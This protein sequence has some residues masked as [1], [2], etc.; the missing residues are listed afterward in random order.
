MRT[1]IRI[2]AVEA[3]DGHAVRVRFSDGV[4]RDLDLGPMLT[5]GVLLGLRDPDVFTA[6][7]VDPVAGTLVW[8]NDVDLDPDVL[9]G[10]SMPAHGA[11]PTLLAERRP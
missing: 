1:L 3:L 8:P 11:A 10:A 2:V 6:V 4:E 9:R 5:D 7:R